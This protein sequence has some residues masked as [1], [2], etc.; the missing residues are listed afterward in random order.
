MQRQLRQASN[1]VAK[2]P[3]PSQ[4]LKLGSDTRQELCIP[5]RKTPESLTGIE[6]GTILNDLYLSQTVAKPPNP[7]QGLKQRLTIDRWQAKRCRKTPESLTGI[8][9]ILLYNLESRFQRSQNP[10]IPHR[11]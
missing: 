11:D 5:C 2:P 10:R 1:C 9:T 8:E 3:N 4:G 6:T 7:S